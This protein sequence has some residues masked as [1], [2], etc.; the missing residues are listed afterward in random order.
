ME[1]RPDEGRSNID[2]GVLPD[3]SLRAGQSPNVEAVQL[4]KLTWMVHFDVMDVV[5]FPLSWFGRDGRAGYQTQA[6]GSR[7]NAVA[8]ENAPYTVLRDPQP[9]PEWTRQLCGDP[10]RSKAWMSQREGHDS[11]LDQDR[12]RI[13]HSRRPT[14]SRTEDLQAEPDGLSVPSVIRRVM[15]SK[16]SA[17]G[18][19]AAQLLG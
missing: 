18:S 2:R 13:G 8:L 19:H 4:H 5:V 10:S 14:F 11:F 15:D 3:R 6:L 12:D 7:I 17:G 1:V 9:T 16:D